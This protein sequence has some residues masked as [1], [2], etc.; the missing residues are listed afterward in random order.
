MGTRPG[1]FCTCP[2]CWHLTQRASRC[3]SLILIHRWQEQ[4]VSLILGLWSWDCLWQEA[5][6]Q[7]ERMRPMSKEE[8][9]IKGRIRWHWAF[10]ALLPE[11][12]SLFLC[13]TSA[14]FS[15]SFS[16]DFQ[17]AWVSFSYYWEFWLV[18]L[19]LLS[20]T[21]STLIF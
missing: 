18:C 3:S 21:V 20:N 15:E 19:T 5:C 2:T 16:S 4:T 9:E 10:E 6:L 14:S 11:V 12:H 17:L 8:R 13:T 1:Q 7:W